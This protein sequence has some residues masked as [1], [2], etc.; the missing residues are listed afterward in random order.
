MW[1][2]RVTARA[3]G[4]LRDQSLELGPGLNVIYGPNEAGKTTWHA[5]IRMAL[6]GVRRGRGQLHQGSLR[7]RGPAPAVGRPRPMGGRGPGPRRRSADRPRPGPPRQGRVPGHRCRP[8]DR[9]LGRDH[10]ARWHAGRVHL[11]GPGPRRVRDHPV[12]G[13]GR[14]AGRGGQRG[15]APG[16]HAA[17]GGRAR[18]RCDRG[19]RHRAPARVPRR[20]VGADTAVAKGPLR[21]AM[22]DVAA[23][24]AELADARRRHAEY[25]GPP[26]RSR[27]RGR[28]AGR[29]RASAGRGS[30]GQ[31]RGPLP[32][33]LRRRADRATELA[34]RYPSPPPP[35][36]AR[37]ELADA[38]A[39]ALAG[40]AR[41]PDPGRWRQVGRSTTSPP[42]SPRCR[43]P[44]IG[45]LQPRPGGVAAVQELVLAEEA[46]RAIGEAAEVPSGEQDASAMR[47]RS[48]PRRRR[49]P[50]RWPGCVALVAGAPLVAAGATVLAVALGAWL[51]VR[52]RRPSTRRA[53]RDTGADLLAEAQARTA[54]ARTALAPRPA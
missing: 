17:G 40:V 39:A 24:E 54:A 7:A 35:L 46:E 53:S 38:V 15:R 34:A 47:P 22:R 21:T 5:A 32:R 44:P 27:C 28:R 42:S 16:A 51:A 30:A 19:R 48:A 23:R 10:P 3:F 37:D 33:T 31:P 11:A 29:G 12:G 9:R 52:N 8:R 18:N 14:D 4:G 49:G 13:P 36:A 20:A 50:P 6:T 25:L 26:G 2:E 41:A 1:I 43:Q 45:D